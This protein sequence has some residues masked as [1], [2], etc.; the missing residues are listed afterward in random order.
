MFGEDNSAQEKGV[1]IEDINAPRLVTG[2]ALL[3]LE[4]IFASRCLDPDAKGISYSGKVC[5]YPPGELFLNA[6]G[7]IPPEK[8]HPD[9]F[10]HTIDPHPACGKF[11]DEY[12]NR[13]ECYL[14]I[15]ENA[16]LEA[17]KNLLADADI[18]MTSINISEIRNTT[19]QY[20]QRLVNFFGREGELRQCNNSINGNFCITHPTQGNAG[21][22]VEGVSIDL[23]AAIKRLRDNPSQRQEQLTCTRDACNFMGVFTTHKIPLSAVLGI[24]VSPLEKMEWRIGSYVGIISGIE[25]INEAVEYIRRLSEKYDVHIP[26]YDYEQNILYSPR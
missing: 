20:F 17:H 25:T 21:K 8:F 11:G 18:R 4:P 10:T 26:V 5:T 16:L 15:D 22:A 6:I 7:V 13:F 23:I 19:N 2:T 1:L 9:P 24:V 14:L 12:F 3:N